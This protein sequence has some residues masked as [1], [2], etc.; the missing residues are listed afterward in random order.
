MDSN[1]LHSNHHIGSIRSNQE[2][3]DMSAQKILIIDDETYFSEYISTALQTEGSYKIEKACD[4]RE[5]VEKYMNFLPDLVIMDIEMPVMDG[6]ESSH[7]I[8]A[9]DP[10]AK[11]LV[12]TGNPTSSR[13]KNT[14]KEGIAFKL[15]QKPIKFRELKSVILANLSTYA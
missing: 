5:G 11:I 10:D 7:K 12:L 14:V 2:I 3:S 4:G 13:A 15:L 9:F 8:K 6:Y 1:P